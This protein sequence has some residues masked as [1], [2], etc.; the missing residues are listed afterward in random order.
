MKNNEPKREKD[1]GVSIQICRLDVIFLLKVNLSLLLLSSCQLV[2]S[3][4]NTHTDL[5]FYTLNDEIAF[6]DSVFDPIEP[7]TS[8]R[9]SRYRR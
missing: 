2:A 7:P 1:G 5:Y 8:P 9:I 6:T 3:P 4:V